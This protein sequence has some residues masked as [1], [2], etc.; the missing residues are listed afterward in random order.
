MPQ[1]YRDTTTIQDIYVVDRE[2]AA[3]APQTQVVDRPAPP[4]SSGFNDFMR[5]KILT[6]LEGRCR[7]SDLSTGGDSPGCYSHSSPGRYRPAFLADS[8]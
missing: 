5:A 3:L 6:D 2:S 7:Y 1:C 4:R 8:L